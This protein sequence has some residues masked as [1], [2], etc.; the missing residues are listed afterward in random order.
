MIY[1]GVG[2]SLYEKMKADPDGNLEMVGWEAH[3]LNGSFLAAGAGD[4]PIPDISLSM[5][6]LIDEIVED[7][8]SRGIVFVDWEDGK[9]WV[10]VNHQV[11][12]DISEAALRELS[13]EY[14][15]EEE[16]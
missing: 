3:L 1:R 15:V 2:I 8:R 4:N 16:V 7:I 6:L 11:P 14:W 12:A 9:T 10:M 5:D 13:R